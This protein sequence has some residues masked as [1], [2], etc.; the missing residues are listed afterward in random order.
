MSNKRLNQ[1]LLWNAYLTKYLVKIRYLKFEIL[2]NLIFLLQ[3][4]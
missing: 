2:Q 4:S 1:G 3:R